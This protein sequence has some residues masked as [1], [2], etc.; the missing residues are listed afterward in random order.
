MS[1]DSFLENRATRN[2]VKKALKGKNDFRFKF[3]GLLTHESKVKVYD[4][5][6][7][8]LG[9]AGLKWF[10]YTIRAHARSDDPPRIHISHRGDTLTHE[11]GRE[12]HPQY[13]APLKPLPNSPYYV[14]K[15]IDPRLT[16]DAYDP[17]EKTDYIDESNE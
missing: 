3:E 16:M 11:R 8:E 15:I 6:D 1:L 7:K 10:A 4:R 13:G 5:I 17:N 2:T 12:P 9:D 14:H